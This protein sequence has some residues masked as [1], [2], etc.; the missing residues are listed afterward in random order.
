MNIGAN[1]GASDQELRIVFFSKSSLIFVSS[2]ISIIYPYMHM[3]IVI[4]QGKKVTFLGVGLEG[5]QGI[6][7][8]HI[9]LV[10]TSSTANSRG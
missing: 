4:G 9:I 1:E 8:Y 7:G 2:Q 10:R 6:G 5:F 3:M